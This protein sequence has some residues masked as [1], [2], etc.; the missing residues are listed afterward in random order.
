MRC[1]NTIRGCLWQGELSVLEGHLN[2]C[3]YAIIPCPNQCRDDSGELVSVARKDLDQHLER[4]CTKRAYKCTSCGE[5]GT[6]AFITQ[7]HDKQCSKKQVACTNK[8]C[9]RMMPRQELKAHVD[10]CKYTPILCPY[11]SIGCICQLPR[12][13]MPDHIKEDK[14]LHFHL[15]LDSL[16]KLDQR[17]SLERQAL[18]TFKVANFKKMKEEGAK[19]QTP[20]L[21]TVPH[22]Y[23][24]A[25]RVYPNGT[26][27]GEGSY[28]SIFTPILKGRFDRK[29]TWPFVGS[30]TFSL[31]NQLEDNNH[32]N[33]LLNTSA[34]D[35]FVIV[36]S[37]WG[38][39]KFIPHSELGYNAKKNTQYLK[40]DTLY[41]RVCVDK[42]NH[43]PWLQ[44]TAPLEPPPSPR[45]VGETVGGVVQNSPPARARLP[46]EPLNV[47]ASDLLPPTP[48]HQP[49]AYM[50]PYSTFKAGVIMSN[51]PT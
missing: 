14:K 38:H 4:D 27:E 21:Y 48:Q 6:Y 51:I 11:E 23:C 49:S 12:R 9:S 26:G 3:E 2:T 30:F 15:A 44:C 28:V 10:E 5:E 16:V 25:V 46:V 47:P 43:K 35:Q 50:V 8:K 19:F 37:A 32:Y 31:L 40:D 1:D 20:S 45:E 13:H 18:H 7:D 17:L 29:L 34:S 36:G 24:I 33:L 42:S 39:P 22:G 41:F